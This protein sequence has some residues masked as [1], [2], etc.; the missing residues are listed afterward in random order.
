MHNL[1]GCTASH[2][3]INHGFSVGNVKID[4]QLYSFTTNAMVKHS[5]LGETIGGLW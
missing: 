1:K 3:E 2:R 4:Y 5:Y